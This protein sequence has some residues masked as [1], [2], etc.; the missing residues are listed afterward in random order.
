MAT[1]DGNPPVAIGLRRVERTDALRSLVVV[2]QRPSGSPVSGGSP[3]IVRAFARRA[4]FDAAL[5]HL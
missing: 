1:W 5:P 2:L 4:R 3:A